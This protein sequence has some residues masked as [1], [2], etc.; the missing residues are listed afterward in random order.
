MSPENNDSDKDAVTIDAFLAAYNAP[1][2][3][4]GFT[5]A[6]M[7]RAQDLQTVQQTTQQPIMTRAEKRLRRGLIYVSYFTGGVIAAAQLPKLLSLWPSSVGGIANN[8][9]TIIPNAPKG[10]ELSTSLL[11]RF[12]IEGFDITSAMTNPL[13]MLPLLAAIVAGVA[14]FWII[15]DEGAGRTL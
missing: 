8:A 5:A 10:S 2:D 3:D 9:G 12:N 4:G 7:Q 11:S 1:I 14:M 6:V 13:A 15:F